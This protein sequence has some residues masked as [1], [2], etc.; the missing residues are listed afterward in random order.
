MFFY[1][2]TTVTIIIITFT[3]TYIHTYDIALCSIHIL[4]V[5]GAFTMHRI[6]IISNRLFATHPN[7]GRPCSNAYKPLITP[8]D[9]EI[10][11]LRPYAF[12]P[13]PCV[14]SFSFSWS[15]IY[16]LIYR[17]YYIGLVHC[18][19]YPPQQPQLFLHSPSHERDVTCD[20]HGH[21]QDDRN[22]CTTVRIHC[23]TSLWV[24]ALDLSLS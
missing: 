12:W 20:H 18:I 13:P 21:Q 6:M 2:I 24:N 9:S 15:D 22:H 16:I 11:K 1:N 14:C 19:I 10:Q 3:H 17:L 5:L 8:M 7:P 23:S 4:Q